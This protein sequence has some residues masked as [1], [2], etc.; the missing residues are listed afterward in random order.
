M[1]ELFWQKKLYK[2][3]PYCIRRQLTQRQTFVFIVIITMFGLFC[4]IFQLVI[5]SYRHTSMKDYYNTYK[6]FDKPDRIDLVNV[7]DQTT[8]KSNARGRL[9]AGNKIH[10]IKKEFLSHYAPD[11]D[12]K[13][14]CVK[15]ITR[16]PFDHVNDDY[17][18]CPLDVEA[19]D[20]PSTGACVNSK[21]YCSGEDKAIPSSR[22]NDG[23]CDCCDGTDEWKQM[24]NVMGLSL[25][26]QMHLAMYSQKYSKY[27][28]YS[29]PCS[30]TC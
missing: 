29:T 23:I 19:S 21:F 2:Q 20:E 4:L 1:E 6:K 28:H 17:C 5:F 13:F 15:S 27:F 24:E 16:V 7:V 12:G 18:D 22:I 8:R 9:V 10:G 25:D 3:L 26:T 14:R 11:S 30:N